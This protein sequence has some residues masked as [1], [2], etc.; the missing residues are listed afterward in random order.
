MK[1]RGI[2][3]SAAPLRWKVTCWFAAIMTVMFPA[4]ANRSDDESWKNVIKEYNVIGDNVVHYNLPTDQQ[5]AV[6]H[7]LNVHGWPTYKLFDRNGNL[8]DL[9]VDARHLEDLA[10]LMEKL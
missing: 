7:F 4:L 1:N 9:N 10:R 3:W 5:A 2:S 8:L 6:E